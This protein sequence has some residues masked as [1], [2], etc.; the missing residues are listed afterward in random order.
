M[1]IKTKTLNFYEKNKIEDDN[2]NKN[3]NNSKFNEMKPI[4]STNI[5]LM[6][7]IIDCNSILG[8]KLTNK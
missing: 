8:Q 6:C 5:D 2:N 7:G 1:K 3:N 4:Y